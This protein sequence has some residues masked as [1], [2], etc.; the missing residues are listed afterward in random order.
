ME[1]SIHLSAKDR[2]TL[3]KVYRG[4]GPANVARRAHVLVLLAEGWSY[5]RIM[6][7]L[8]A[9]SELVASSEVDLNAV[10]W[11]PCWERNPTT[12]LCCP[13]GAFCRPCGC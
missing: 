2:K 6:S 12:L 3:I 1:G 5:R 10:E 8:F 9:S 11:R 7:D 13:S 4:S